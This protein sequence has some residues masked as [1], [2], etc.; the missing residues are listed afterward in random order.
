MYAEIVFRFV[1]DD[2]EA[3]FCGITQP[4]EN[5]SNLSNGVCRCQNNLKDSVTLL[6]KNK[7]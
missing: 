2:E 3:G 1:S 6:I 4:D 5:C 7:E